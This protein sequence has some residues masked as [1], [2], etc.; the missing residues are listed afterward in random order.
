MPLQSW[1]TVAAG[2]FFFVSILVAVAVATVLGEVTSIVNDLHD[3]ER[4]SAVP[5]ARV[6][7]AERSAGAGEKQYVAQVV[8]LR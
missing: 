5:A 4:W 3:T 7:G 6:L 8:R 2:S 1:I